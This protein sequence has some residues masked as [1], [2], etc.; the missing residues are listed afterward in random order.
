MAAGGTVTILVAAQTIMLACTL[1]TINKLLIA[2]TM[3]PA[4]YE[5]MKIK[6]AALAIVAVVMTAALFVIRI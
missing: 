6:V 5:G 2:R 4:I 3:N 1:S